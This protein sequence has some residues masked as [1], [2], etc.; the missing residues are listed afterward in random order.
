[1]PIASRST[2]SAKC[3]SRA[4]TARMA[5]RSRRFGSG[6][7]TWRSNRPGRSNAGSSVSGRFVAASTTT[8]A[9]GF[10]AV[11]LREHLVQGLLAFVVRDVAGAPALADGI[12]LVDEDDRG[13]RLARRREEISHPR[14]AD[15]DEQLDEAGPGQREERHVR[16]AGNGAAPRGS[17]PVPGG[18]TINTPAVSLPR[19]AA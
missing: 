9:V 3:L 14:R 15:A 13:C 8:L 6:I 1:M 7:S 2:S 18:P 19:R 17:C 5:A 11:H 4:C 10:E 12:D 16:F